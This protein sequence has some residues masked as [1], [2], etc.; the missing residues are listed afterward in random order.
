M[1]RRY[2]NSMYLW[3]VESQER[4]VLHWHLIYA[5]DWDIKFGR[6]DIEKIQQYWKY[7][8]VEV[9]PVKNVKFEYLLKYITKALAGSDIENEEFVTELNKVR[10]IGSSMI[11]GHLKQSWT[12][13]L[14][15]VSWF[16]QFGYSDLSEFYWSNGRAFLKTEERKQ[17]MIYK[18]PSEW[19]LVC[20]SSMTEINELF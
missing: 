20:K 1:K 13:V 18:P 7:G 12:K 6:E 19:K 5:F 3:T 14:K 16:M 11:S 10:R 2:K 17:V 4:G 8:S 9:V 15:A